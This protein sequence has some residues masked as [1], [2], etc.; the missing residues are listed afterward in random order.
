MNS[1]LI[2]DKPLPIALAAE[3]YCDNITE[4]MLDVIFKEAYSE[5]IMERLMFLASSE[6]IK[7]K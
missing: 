4:D 6:P 1:E 3:E 7:N 2:P 5:D